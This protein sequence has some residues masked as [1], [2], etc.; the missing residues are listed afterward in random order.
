MLGE[1]DKFPCEHRS[2]REFPIFTVHF[3]G[4]V[5]YV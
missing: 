3:T 4:F 2:Q 1:K 5:S